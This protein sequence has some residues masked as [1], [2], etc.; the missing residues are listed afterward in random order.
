M[1]AMTRGALLGVALAVALG[2][3]GAAARA[4]DAA[5]PQLNA[6]PTFIVLDGDG[7]IVL[8]TQGWSSK[9]EHDVQSAVSHTIDQLAAAT[10]PAATKP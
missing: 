2:Q 7:R 8:T 1:P 4:A 6:F 10:P 9:R 5:N 3:P